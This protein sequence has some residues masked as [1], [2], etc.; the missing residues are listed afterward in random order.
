MEPTEDGPCDD[1]AGGRRVIRRAFNGFGNPLVDALLRT[2]D[3][4]VRID[5]L[6]QAF[7]EVVL[8]QDN[9]V[10]QALSPDGAEKAFADRIQVRRFR[11]DLHRLYPSRLDGGVE[12]GTKLRVVVPDDE[13]RPLSPGSRLADLLGGP[14]VRGR[15]GDVE[16]YDLAA[17]VTDDEERKDRPEPD[18][19][20]L[21]KDTP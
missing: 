13:P 6:P 1:L 8:T 15:P 2:R 5:I 16:M 11:R 18:V 17:P 20:M 9:D 3:V 12:L 4:E 21:P 7:A 14:L 19:V 10:G